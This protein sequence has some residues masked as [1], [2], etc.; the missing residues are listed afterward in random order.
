MMTLELNPEDLDVWPAKRAIETAIAS[1]PG[2]KH[3]EIYFSISSSL[4]LEMEKGS[5][6]KSEASK[7]I[8]F[9]IRV[10][11]DKGQSAFSHASKLD[12]S[13]IEKT[14]TCI[15]ISTNIKRITSLN[16]TVICGNGVS[17]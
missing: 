9:G 15:N 10:A 5:M 16:R 11:N 13:A 1:F 12:T 2:V 14:V 4:G 3:H 7:D 17:K 8:G 6:K